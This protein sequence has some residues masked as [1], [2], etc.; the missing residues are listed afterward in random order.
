LAGGVPGARLNQ[1]DDG[2]L[3]RGNGGD[4]G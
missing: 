2:A 4:E 3:S 1:P